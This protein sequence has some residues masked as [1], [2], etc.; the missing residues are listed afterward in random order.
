VDAQR[1]NDRIHAGRGKA[2]LRIGFVYRVY[3]PN[4]VESPF[5]NYITAVHAGF[6]AADNAYL[7]PNQFGKPIL[8]AD[9]DGRLTRAGDY[10]VRE[11]TEGRDDIYFIAAQQSLLPIIA[12]DCP[13]KLYIERQ[14]CGGSSV[15]VTN[16]SGQ[17]DPTPVLG[18]KDTPWPASIVIGGRV[19]ASTG[20]PGGVREAAWSVL[21]PP[22]VPCVI[23]SG[24]ILIDDM[25]RRMATESAELTDLG[26]RLIATEVHT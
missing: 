23:E 6:N 20:L 4:A 2:A 14:P 25:K 1:I 24:D 15:G 22:S 11:D 19:Q 8:F 21:L 5:S 3:R 7:K 13:R 18:N 10:L 17:A 26:W 12:I 16:Y 9:L